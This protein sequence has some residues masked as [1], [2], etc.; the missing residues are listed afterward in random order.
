MTSITHGA[1]V[2]G[3][4]AVLEGPAGPEGGNGLRMQQG[5]TVG[6]CQLTAMQPKNEVL[7][8]GELF[9]NAAHSK[10]IIRKRAKIFKGVGAFP[11]F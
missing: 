4:D 9:A 6:K 10:Q 8:K 7:G 11:C 1:H 5:Q 3:G 2:V